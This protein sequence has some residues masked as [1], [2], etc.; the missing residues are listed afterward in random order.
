M[1]A[2]HLATRLRAILP[3]T[4][5]PPPRVP[6]LG[7]ANAVRDE[8]RRF[9]AMHPR[10]CVLTGAGISTAS[11]IPDYRG[12]DGAWKRNAPITHAQFMGDPAFRAR[13]WQRSFA[14]WHTVA[15][16]RPNGAHHALAR[17]AGDGTLSGLITQNVDGLHAR[18]GHADA[19]DLHGRIDR[20]ICTRCGQTSA[21]DALQPRLAAAHPHWQRSATPAPDGDAEVDDIDA[22]R[23]VEPCCES[24]GGML[25]PDVVFFGGSVPPARIAAATACIDAAD[26]LLVA[27]SSL[28]V[29]SGYRLVR[30]AVEGGKPVA[31]LTRGL[32]RAD[33]LATHRWAV[34][35]GALAHA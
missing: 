29:F 26:A 24:C 14:G 1:A 6:A 8:L 4:I 9:R 31:L 20:V 30:R 23:Y 13:Y 21:R 19:I 17:W 18:A 11:G 32:T 35:C 22:S 33:D 15:N 7:D 27:G 16:A 5:T 12:N 28:M 25:K 34:D 2:P 10:M 3:R